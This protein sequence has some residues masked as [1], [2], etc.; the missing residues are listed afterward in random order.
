MSKELQAL[1]NTNSKRADLSK[2]F[3]K[4]DAIIKYF[5]D[6]IPKGNG[7]FLLLILIIIDLLR[8]FGIS[9]WYRQLN[10]SQ[11]FLIAVSQTI[12][13]YQF[14][15]PLPSTFKQLSIKTLKRD[16]LN[17]LNSRSSY[18]LLFILGGLQENNRV[19]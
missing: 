16:I 5:M 1:H 17:Y 12:N 14:Y 4:V 8:V 9:I 3:Y 10:I 6:N 15:N 13:T 19:I 2:Q 7:I 18:V 11:L